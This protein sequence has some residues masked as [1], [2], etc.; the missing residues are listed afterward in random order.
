MKQKGVDMD[1]YDIDE[2]I[3]ECEKKRTDDEVI[4]YAVGAGRIMPMLGM[5]KAIKQGMDY[6]QGLKGFLGF[7]PVDLW[8]TMVIFDTL[9]NAKG[10]KNLMNAKGIPTGKYVVPIL[11]P[12]EFEHGGTTDP[13]V[14]REAFKKRG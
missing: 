3:A 4:A 8:H 10:G 5:T 2:M 11:I 9:N 12:K 6:I 14:I 1:K 13:K 7:N